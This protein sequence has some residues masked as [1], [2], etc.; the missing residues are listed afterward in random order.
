VRK[1]AVPKQLRPQLRP[2]S[3][4]GR[5]KTPPTLRPISSSERLRLAL[6]TGDQPRGKLNEEQPRVDDAWLQTEEKPD[7]QLRLLERLEE[8]ENALFEAEKSWAKERSTLEREAQRKVAVEQEKANE[9]KHALET[10][11]FAERDKIIALQAEAARFKTQ[12]QLAEVR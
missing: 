11:L 9:A 2:L 3:D 5:K 10:E 12:A 6:T 4:G 1:R 7:D 8:R